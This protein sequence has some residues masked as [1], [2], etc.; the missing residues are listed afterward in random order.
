MNFVMTIPS[1]YSK[2]KKSWSFCVMWMWQHLIRNTIKEEKYK[3]RSRYHFR[4]VLGLFFPF[5]PPQC[6]GLAVLLN[7]MFYIS[8]WQT[9]KTISASFWRKRTQW[10]QFLKWLL[11]I[12]TLLNLVFLNIWR[13]KMLKLVLDLNLCCKNI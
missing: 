12:F 9:G 2:K 7:C 1:L 11:I 10:N 8:W 13:Q 5:P 4:L 3:K 6:L